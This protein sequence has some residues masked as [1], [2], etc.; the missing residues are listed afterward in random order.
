MYGHVVFVTCCVLLPCYCCSETTPFLES[1]VDDRFNSTPPHTGIS[2]KGTQVQK[3]GFKT[4]AAAAHGHGGQQQHPSKE[5]ATSTSNIDPG[6]TTHPDNASVDW[7]ILGIV[8]TLQRQQCSTGFPGVRYGSSIMI[9]VPSI[10][11]WSHPRASAQI[12][13]Q[14]LVEHQTFV[15]AFSPLMPCCLGFVAAAPVASRFCCCSSCC[16]TLRA[17]A[18]VKGAEQDQHALH[19]GHVDCSAARLTWALS[20]SDIHGCCGTHTDQLHLEW[21]RPDE[22]P[23]RYQLHSHIPPASI[24][25]KLQDSSLQLQAPSRQ[26]SHSR[27]LQ[28]IPYPVGAATASFVPHEQSLC[29]HSTTVLF[30][31]HNS[32]AQATMGHPNEWLFVQEGTAYFTS[33]LM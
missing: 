22:H 2:R 26:L 11:S 14:T 10:T 27:Q 23:V 30:L 17:N 4:P 8:S 13:T 31:A 5:R 32:A 3:I 9:D 19:C 25:S 20:Q 28:S 33:C 29:S 16:T 18:G 12:R 15:P 7:S 6:M 24:P 1:Q 21:L